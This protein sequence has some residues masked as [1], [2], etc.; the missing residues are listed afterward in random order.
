MGGG[1]APLHWHGTG[2]VLVWHWPGTEPA[3]VLPGTGAVTQL[4][5]LQEHLSGYVEMS[6]SHEQ[7]SRMEELVL[8][9]FTLQKGS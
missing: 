9:C 1:T 4:I 3:L 5:G 7:I 6:T 2:L 8:L